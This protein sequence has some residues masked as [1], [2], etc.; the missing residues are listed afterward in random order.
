MWGLEIAVLANGPC[1]EFW[2]MIPNYDTMTDV[3]AQQMYHSIVT[4]E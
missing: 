4:K 2:Y 3:L 1:I